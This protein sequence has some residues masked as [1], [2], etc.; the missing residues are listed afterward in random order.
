[1]NAFWD[2][3]GSQAE[4]IYEVAWDII[5]HVDMKHKNVQYIHLYDEGCDLDFDMTLHLF[6]LLCKFFEEDKN[7]NWKEKYPA[8]APVMM[9]AITRKKEIRERVDVNFDGRV[10]FL[11]YLLYQYN[12]TPKS[13]M[14]RSAPQDGPTNPALE[15]ARLALEE[16]NKKIRE[17][18][19]ERQRLITLS[20]SNGGQGVKAL[21]AKNQ[22][23]QLDSSPLAEQLRK[24]LITAEAAVRIASKGLS[25]QPAEGGKAQPRVDGALWW[26]NYDLQKKK[27]KYG[28]PAK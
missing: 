5:K 20:E 23:A 4:C 16:V 3:V 22:L 21:G 1:M 18:E 9:T 12:V 15:K 13:L 2:E 27:A 6:E 24:M 17:Y 8:S 7:K 10:S 11:E 19:A 28:A 14:E 25:Q 26:M